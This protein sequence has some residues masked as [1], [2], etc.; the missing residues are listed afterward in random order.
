[1]AGLPQG[2]VEEREQPRAGQMGRCVGCGLHL[3]HA[4][5]HMRW[6]TKR[7]RPSAGISRAPIARNDSMTAKLVW[8]EVSSAGVELR[9]AARPGRAARPD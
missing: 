6:S 9:E 1:M 5:M 8:L 4:R 2:P 3:K 7:C